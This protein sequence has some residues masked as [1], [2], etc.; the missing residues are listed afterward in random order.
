MRKSYVRYFI[1]AMLGLSLGWM[2]GCG[3]KKM[4]EPE[5]VVIDVIIEG[6]VGDGN[7]CTTGDS[8]ASGAA[9][10][11]EYCAETGGT[12]HAGKECAKVGNDCV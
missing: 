10:T 11:K 3:D 1:L 6:A 4:G 12:F 8:C 9:V 2:S 5:D 7:C